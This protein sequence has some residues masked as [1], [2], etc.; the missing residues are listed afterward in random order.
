LLPFQDPRQIQPEQDNRQQE[1]NAE[2]K[3]QPQH[4]RQVHLGA[5][6]I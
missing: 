3:Q 6:E 1:G 2:G 4:K 5:N